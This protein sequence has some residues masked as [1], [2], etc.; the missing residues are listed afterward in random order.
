MDIEQSQC[1]D[2]DPVCSSSANST[3]S[4]TNSEKSPELLLNDLA[5]DHDLTDDEVSAALQFSPDPA[6]FVLDVMQGSYFKFW[7][8][9]K[10]DPLLT[11]NIILLL[12]ELMKIA[13]KVS[14]QVKEAAVKQVLLWK[15]N[16]SLEPQNSLE[17]LAFLM[18]LAIYDLVSYFRRDEVVRL[19]ETI[20]RYKQAPETCRILGFEYV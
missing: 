20:V 1:S 3:S 15:E 18:F 17:I 8:N 5:V 9:G 12:E 16:I 7:N 11:R 6:K 14:H 10:F 13:P 4:V 19:V 2:S